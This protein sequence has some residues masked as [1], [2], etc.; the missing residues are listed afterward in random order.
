MIDVNRFLF[1]SPRFQV[2]VWYQNRRTKHKRLKTEDG[3]NSSNEINDD[4]PHDQSIEAEEEDDEEDDQRREQD[5][6][7]HR[8]PSDTSTKTDDEHS[9]DTNNNPT[10]SHRHYPFLSQSST[11]RSSDSDRYY[12]PP[13]ISSKDHHR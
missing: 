5:E 1:L 8:H 6:D 11:P 7:E 3:Q 10:H 2:K 9:W 12:V 13:A 4:E